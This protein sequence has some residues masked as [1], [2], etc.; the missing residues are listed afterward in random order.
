MGADKTFTAFL[1]HQRLGSGHLDEILDLIRDQGV[2]GA[3]VFADDTGDL[4][5]LSTAAEV[6][7]ALAAQEPQSRPSAST[8]VEMTTRFLPRHLRWLEAQ[9]GGPAAALRR[10]VDAARHGDGDPARRAKEAAYRFISMTAGDL[11]G[12]EAATRAL[13]AGDRSAFNSAIEAWPGDLGDY[14]RRLALPA[15]NPAP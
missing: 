9:P 15:L 3:L 6:E 14:G 12:F 11:P 7:A 5:K 1:G 8:P 10:L 13:F 2:L 4:V